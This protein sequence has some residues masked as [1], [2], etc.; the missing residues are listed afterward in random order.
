MYGYSEAEALEMNIADIV[1]RE[2]SKEALE[3]V[4]C[5]FRGELVSSFETQRVCKD[6]HTLDVWLTATLVPGDGGEP[7]YL[8]TT[9]RNVMEWQGPRKPRGSGS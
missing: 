6:G 8:A 2:K 7:A 5:A 9:E 4:K 3:F 1:P